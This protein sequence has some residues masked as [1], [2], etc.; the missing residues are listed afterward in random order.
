M[1]TSRR[2]RSSRHR[3]GPS[4]PVH[5]VG[6]VRGTSIQFLYVSGWSVL[7]INA[8]TMQRFLFMEFSNFF[9]PR[10]ISHAITGSCQMAVHSPALAAPC[11]NRPRPRLPHH[12]LPAPPRDLRPAPTR[13]LLSVAFPTS[14]ALRPPPAAREQRGWA[15]ISTSHG[16]AGSEFCQGSPLDID[17]TLIV[18]GITKHHTKNVNAC[19]N[20]S[21]RSGKKV[22]S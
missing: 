13:P 12:R 9:S 10:F 16:P 18:P 21:H 15:C 1:R 8:L 19:P 11:K 2:C 5:A 20:S 7:I 3:T 4:V 22:L 17:H 6:G 14:P